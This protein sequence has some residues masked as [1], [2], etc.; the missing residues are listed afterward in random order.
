[1]KQEKNK[2]DIDQV[3]KPQHKFKYG[4]IKHTYLINLVAILALF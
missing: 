4:M 1:M 2:L 3:F